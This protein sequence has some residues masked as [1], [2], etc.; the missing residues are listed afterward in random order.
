MAGKIKTLIDE[1]IELRTGGNPTLAG[2][3]RTILIVRGI[4]PTKYGPDSEDDPQV[5]SKLEALL[6]EF[7]NEQ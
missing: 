6:A 2:F 5:I 7:R 3:V 1:L 4:N